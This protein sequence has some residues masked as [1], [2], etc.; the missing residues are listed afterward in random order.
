VAFKIIDVDGNGKITR[1]EFNSF[2]LA[3]EL[4]FLKDVFNHADADHN[5]TID[6]D[7]LIRNNNGG[8]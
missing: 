5:G 2:V 4:Y 3:T 6:V 8:H 1:D 7:E